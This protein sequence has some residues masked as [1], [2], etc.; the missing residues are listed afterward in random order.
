MLCEGGPA[1]LTAFAQQDLLDELCLTVTPLLL[2]R[3]PQL[4]S[5]PLSA[6]R[7]LDLVSLVD[8]GDG[9]LLARYAL[10]PSA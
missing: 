3:S 2:G 4:L 6:P 1:L 10:R 8:G 9:A 7:R 5:E